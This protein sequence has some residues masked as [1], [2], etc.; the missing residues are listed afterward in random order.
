MDL[1]VG[2][3]VTQVVLGKIFIQIRY[4]EISCGI[5]LSMLWPVLLLFFF[6]L[7]FFSY[8]LIVIFLSRAQWALGS[9][10]NELW[11]TRDFGTSWSL[12]HTGVYRYSWGDA[13]M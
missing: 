8:Y 10:N 2:C 13:G 7:F 1:L 5:L 3:L 4:L 11:I 6:F 12:V 9:T